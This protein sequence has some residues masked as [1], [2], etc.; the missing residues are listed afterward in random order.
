MGRAVSSNRTAAGCVCLMDRDVTPAEHA[1]LQEE[2]ERIGAPACH[3]AGLVIQ[4][5]TVA[6]LEWQKLRD[7]A[8]LHSNLLRGLPARL[9]QNQALH[10]IGDDADRIAQIEAE[11]LRLMQALKEAGEVMDGNAEAADW[12]ERWAVLLERGERRVEG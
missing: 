11:N 2:L 7:P 9:T 5:L 4:R 12:R 10:L 1:T 3:E 8:V 6:L